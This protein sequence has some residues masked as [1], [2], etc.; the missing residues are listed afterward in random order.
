MSTTIHVYPTTDYLPLVEETRLRTQELFQWFLHKQNIGGTLEVQAFYQGKRRCRVESSVRWQVGMDL[1]F[2]YLI[3]G[4]WRGGSWPELW[5]RDRIDQWWVDDYEK[6]DGKFGF[7]SSMLGQIVPLDNDDFAGNL[8]EEEL[9]VVNSFDYFWDEY[10][11]AGAP[12]VT[13]VGYGFA[14]AAL[15]EETNGRLV[16]FDGAFDDIGH[17][18]EFAD[19]FLSWWGDAQMKFYGVDAFRW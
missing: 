11:N 5:E 19:Q 8:S 10:R 15:A 14:A 12:A 9:R 6:S 2:A 17:N 1:G 16:S 4:E 18:G 7:P 3:D 13:S